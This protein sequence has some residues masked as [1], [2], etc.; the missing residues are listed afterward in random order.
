MAGPSAPGRSNRTPAE[1]R[2]G[3]NGFTS[4]LDRNRG[5]VY[6]VPQHVSLPE[7]G[8]CHELVDAGSEL[9]TVIRI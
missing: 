5:I 2:V 4:L 1:M 7:E 9:S 3:R 6:F 8:L